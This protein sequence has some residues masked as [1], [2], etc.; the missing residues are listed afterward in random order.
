MLREQR[1]YLKNRPASVFLDGFFPWQLAK[2]LLTQA[3]IRKDLPS[4]R[5]TD[6]EISRL[7]SFIKNFSAAVTAVSS[8]SQAQVCL[9]GV[10]TL[11]VKSETMGIPSRARPLFCRR[12]P[13]CGRDLRRIQSSVGLVQRLAGRTLGSF[14]IQ[15]KSR[16]V[17]EYI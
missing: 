12:D 8:F 11:Q 7:A 16:K 6:E 5:I 1:D 15:E 3:R 13:G 10:D 17:T 9:G 4:G 14:K 2:V